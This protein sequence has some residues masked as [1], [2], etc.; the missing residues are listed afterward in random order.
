MMSE[1]H[2]DQEKLLNT[3]SDLVPGMVT[4]FVI[5]AEFVDSNGERNLYGLTMQD[6]RSYETLGLLAYG[7]AVERRR[8][9]DD[10]F[11]D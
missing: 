3:L 11:S 10:F 4:K 5:I 7:D 6:Q 8:V 1:E 9:T 2:P